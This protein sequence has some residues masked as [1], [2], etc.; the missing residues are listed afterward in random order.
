M[1]IMN[2]MNANIGIEHIPQVSV[3]GKGSPGPVLLFVNF[4]S[5]RHEICWKESDGFTQTCQRTAFDWTNDKALSNL[6]YFDFLCGLHNR[7]L[8]GN[9]NRQEISTHKHP[10]QHENLL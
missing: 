5:L 3:P 1:M 10:R 8:L 4:T 6:L 9:T 7:Q 2:E